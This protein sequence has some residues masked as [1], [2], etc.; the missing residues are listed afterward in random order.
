MLLPHAQRLLLLAAVLLFCSTYA[1]FIEG[2]D[3]S[4]YSIVGDEMRW[5]VRAAVAFG[6]ASVRRSTLPRQKN[7]ASSGMWTAVA[8]TAYGAY[9]AVEGIS[10]V[11]SCVA[12]STARARMG[13]MFTDAAM[14]RPAMNRGR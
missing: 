10:W 7:L 6:G 3:G 14:N 13:A 2:G 4:S 9:S 11:A 5:V 8:L 1:N 12:A